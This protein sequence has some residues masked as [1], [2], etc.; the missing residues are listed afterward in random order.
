[1][2]QLNQFDSSFV[3]LQ[4]LASL[5]NSEADESDEF[6]EI[7]EWTTK[8]SRFCFMSVFSCLTND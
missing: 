4:W 7:D 6:D 2:K 5:K 8:L 3:K 1:M